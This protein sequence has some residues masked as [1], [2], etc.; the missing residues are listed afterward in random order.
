MRNTLAFGLALFLSGADALTAIAGQPS[1]DS[2]AG[3]AGMKTGGSMPAA[4]SVHDGWFRALPGGLPSGGYFTLHNDGTAALT[5]TGTS[6]PA[7]G[8][9]ML[10]KSENTGGMSSMADVMS[11]DVPAGK[12]VS[13]APG[14]YHLMCMQPGAAMKPGGKA[15]VTFTF[16]GGAT[17]DADFAIRNAAGK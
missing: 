6:S 8:M 3:M 2:M 7:C 11:V 17:L 9:L 1:D 16:A 12:S 14:G 13:F 4:A 15:K 10:H 5:L